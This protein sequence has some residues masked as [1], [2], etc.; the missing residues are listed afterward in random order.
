MI[1]CK[2]DSMFDLRNEMNGKTGKKMQKH[3]TR[4]ILPEL[5]MQHVSLAAVEFDDSN[6][7]CF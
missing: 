6:K 5:G 4:I 7:V 3:S 1:I 2:F